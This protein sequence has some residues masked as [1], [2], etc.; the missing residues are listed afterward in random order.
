MYFSKYRS[1]CY[2]DWARKILWWDAPCAACSPTCEHWS[3][4]LGQ[5]S[6]NT[7][8]PEGYWSLLP[9]E[10]KVILPYLQHLSSS[11]LP[12]TKSSNLFFHSQNVFFPHGQWFLRS[13][14]SN[15]PLSC[16]VRHFHRSLFS[17]IREDTPECPFFRVTSISILIT[18]WS[19]V[20][21]MFPGQYLFLNSE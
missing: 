10:D 21:C 18:F 1:D 16:A 15:L 20:V 19:Q 5:G 8:C 17:T 11:T 12:P 3:T 6:G 7:D 9:L 13:Y 4:W 2:L 14:I